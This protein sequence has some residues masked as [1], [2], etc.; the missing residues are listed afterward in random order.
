MVGQLLLRGMIAGILA[1]LLAFGF[2]KVYGEPM[3]D[4]AIAFETTMVVAPVPADAGAADAASGGGM[5]GTDMRKADLADPQIFSRAT[6]SGL[7]LFTGLI[8]YGTAFG[9]LFALVFA[10]AWGRMG[11]L[12]PRSTAAVLALL[13][14]IAVILVPGLKNPAGPPS[15][16]DAATIVLRTQVYFGMIVLSLAGMTGAVWLARRLWVR[17]GGW[18]ASIIAGAALLV[19]LGLVASVMPDINEVPEGFPA[20]VLWQFRI[21]AWGIQAVL[22]AGIGLGFGAMAERYLDAQGRG[23]VAGRVATGRV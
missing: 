19:G 10:F 21:A 3:V 11:P 5:S 16:G 20:V 8:I 17:F 2:A 9:G 14:F 6:Q 15:V 7:G 4:R 1:A 12:G 13:G 22:W 23:R 18:N